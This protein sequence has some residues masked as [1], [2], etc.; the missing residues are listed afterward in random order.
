MY[1]EVR[2]NNGMTI[3]HVVDGNVGLNDLQIHYFVV[4]P[5]DWKLWSQSLK[6]VQQIELTGHMSPW[7]H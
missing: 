1:S 3:L 4:G 7:S 6:I 2:L 5:M